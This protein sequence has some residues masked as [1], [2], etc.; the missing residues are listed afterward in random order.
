MNNTKELEL[1][2]EIWLPSLHLDVEQLKRQDKA[3]CKDLTPIQIENSTGKFR[4]SKTDYMTSLSDCNCRDFA[5]RRK[6]CKHMYRLASELGIYKLKNVSSSNT[7]NLKKRI[8]EIMPIIES[9]TDDEQKEFKDIAYYCGNKGDSNGLILSDIELANKY[10]KLDL[11]QI[12][13][14]RKKIYTL[15]N[16]NDLRKLIHD[17][18]IK[19]PRKKDELIDFI[20]HNYPDIDLPVNPNKVHIELHQSIEHLGYTIHKRLCKKFPKENPDYFWL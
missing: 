10:L 18:T 2:W 4:G 12:V 1:Q 17:K 8:E 20:I 7:V 3:V 5:I 11:V 13:T 15:T 16:Y 6:P 9:M 19:L 14:D